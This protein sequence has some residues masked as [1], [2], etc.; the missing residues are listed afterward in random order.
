MPS[1]QEIR[2]KVKVRRV[3]GGIAGHLP[4]LNRSEVLVAFFTFFSKVAAQVLGTR[5]DSHQNAR[6]R[7]NEYRP[8]AGGGD[9][10]EKLHLL[11]PGRGVLPSQWGKVISI[12]AKIGG[13][14][15][16]LRFVSLPLYLGF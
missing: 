4:N 7:G 2:R 8:K 9:G 10:V 11:Q 13:F 1:Q 15:L 6:N 14:H 5:C 16:D 3:A 12:S